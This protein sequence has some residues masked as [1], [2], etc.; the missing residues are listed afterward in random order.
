MVAQTQKLFKMNERKEEGLEINPQVAFEKKFEYVQNV[1]ISGRKIT[2]SMSDIDFI[3]NHIQAVEF[4][5]VYEESP[6]VKNVTTILKKIVGY[7]DH[8][9]RVNEMQEWTK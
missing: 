5:Y 1:G 9:E 4:S 2:L 7:D 3:C 8:I 6:A